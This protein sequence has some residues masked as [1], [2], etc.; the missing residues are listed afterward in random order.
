[1]KAASIYAYHNKDGEYK[2][3]KDLSY[4]TLNDD[5]SY[6]VRGNLYDFGN[7]PVLIRSKTGTLN[8][9]WWFLDPVREPTRFP[10]KDGQPGNPNKGRRLTFGSLN[11]LKGQ[12]PLK[13][14]KNSL[15]SELRNNW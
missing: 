15:L 1:M 2:L 3:I 5:G 6:T 12:K 9:R 13:K 14:V 4:A 10:S 11:V 8:F 7:G